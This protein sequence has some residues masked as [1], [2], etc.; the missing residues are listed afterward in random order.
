MQRFQAKSFSHTLTHFC[1]ELYFIQSN[2]HL[3]LHEI[4]HIDLFLTPSK[5]LTRLS[6]LL[7]QRQAGNNS[8]K[9]KNKTRQIKI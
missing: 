8:H 4:C 1:F 7:V 6:V 3:H 9:L 2:S 5:L